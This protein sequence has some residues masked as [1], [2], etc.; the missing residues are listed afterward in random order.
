MDSRSRQDGALQWPLSIAEWP[1]RCHAWAGAPTVPRLQS[2]KPLNTKQSG[3][4][5]HNQIMEQVKC[6]VY[7]NTASWTIRNCMG[8]KVPMDTIATPKGK[9]ILGDKQNIGQKF[10]HDNP[11][12]PC[13]ESTRFNSVP[14]QLMEAETLQWAWKAWGT[15]PHQVSFEKLWKASKT[16]YRYMLQC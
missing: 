8:V 11:I 4:S 5:P 1:W 9:Q 6:K 15:N 7:H 3:E 10:N 12:R 2:W 13:W 16:G 14:Q